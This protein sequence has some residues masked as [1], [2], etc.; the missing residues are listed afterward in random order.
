MP[1]TYTN[2]LNEEK[3]FIFTTEKQL[4]NIDFACKGGDFIINNFH[5][6]E[7]CF[8][9][10]CVWLLAKPVDIARKSKKQVA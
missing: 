7:M 8:R 9:Q 5:I 4:A 6:I 10:V 3:V 2:S 1:L